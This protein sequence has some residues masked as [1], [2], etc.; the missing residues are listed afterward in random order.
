LI[1]RKLL[2]ASPEVFTTDEY[3]QN[4]RYSEE[5]NAESITFLMVMAVTPLLESYYAL[6]KSLANYFTLYFVFV[7]QKN[8]VPAFTN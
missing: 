1:K 3:H 6:V 2:S 8:A 5:S 7:K 4:L